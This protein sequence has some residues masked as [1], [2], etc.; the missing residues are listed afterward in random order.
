MDPRYA[1]DA[2]HPNLAGHKVMEKV[3]LEII[4]Q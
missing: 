1:G 4:H 3:L 2:V